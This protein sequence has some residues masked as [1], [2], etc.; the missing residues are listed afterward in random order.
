MSDGL[1]DG[2]C[3][4][5]GGDVAAMRCSPAIDGW[6][7]DFLSAAGVQATKGGKCFTD[8][9]VSAPADWTLWDPTSIA[10]SLRN[11]VQRV[12]NRLFSEVDVV[13]RVYVPLGLDRLQHL[14]LLASAGPRFLGW[15]GLW[16]EEPFTQTEVAR[17]S[18]QVSAIRERLMTIDDLGSAAVSWAIVESTLEAMERPAFL[19]RA[20]N[21]VELANASARALLKRS[22]R[23]ML[24]LIERVLAGETSDWS[25]SYFTDVGMPDM[26]IVSQR[27]S[28]STFERVIEYAQ[29]SW[30]LSATQVAVLRLVARGFSN[31]EIAADLGRAEGTIELHVSA[32][33]RRA[34]VESRA[35]L[36]AKLW[37]AFE[38]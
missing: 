22:R 14:T 18:I 12:D 1:V 29:R 5:L 20:P 21:R 8:Y 6:H 25:V 27:P 33:F 17:L 31:K 19:V 11:T 10:P 4:A 16:R 9:I 3:E 32:I 38:T 30:R 35:R 2:L 15:I 7:L 37:Q 13:K 24:S 26:A 34:N 23:S 36:Q 28:G